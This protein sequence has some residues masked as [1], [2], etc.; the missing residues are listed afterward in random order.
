MLEEREGNINVIQTVCRQE[1]E[2][3]MG[4]PGAMST[5]AFLYH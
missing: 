1:L 4:E 5:H 2:S 3:K